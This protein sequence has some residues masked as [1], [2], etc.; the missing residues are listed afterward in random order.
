M[1]KQK[2]LAA[3]VAMALGLAALPALA[4]NGATSAPMLCRPSR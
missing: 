2:P 4:Q 1:L 3:A